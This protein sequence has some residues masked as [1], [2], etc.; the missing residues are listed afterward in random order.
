MRSVM[1]RAISLKSLTVF[2]WDKSMIESVPGIMSEEANTKAP[3]LT[4]RLIEEYRFHATI[5]NAGNK[6]PGFLFARGAGAATPVPNFL[7]ERLNDHLP[8]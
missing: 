6:L 4:N 8:I 1:D 2:Q 5:L 7:A 3:R